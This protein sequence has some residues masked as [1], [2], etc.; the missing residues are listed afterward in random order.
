[1]EL[2]ADGSSVATNGAVTSGQSYTGYWR[3][4]NNSVGGA[5]PTNFISTYSG[6][7]DDVR[8][9][10]ARLTSTDVSN[11]YTSVGAYA[12]SGACTYYWALDATSGTS[13]ADSVGS[14]TGTLQN[15]SFP[16]HPKNGNVGTLTGFAFNS[17]DGW[18]P[19]VFGEG[20]KFNTGDYVAGENPFLASTLDNYSV[21][22][23]FNTT[24][25]GGKMAGMC[26]DTACTGRDRFLDIDSTNGKVRFV[27]YPNSCGD[28][29]STN[30]YTDGAWHFAVGTLSS[31]GMKLYVDGLL[32]ASD[33]GV[34]SGFDYG[35]SNNRAILF[36]GG[37]SLGCTNGSANYVGSL[38][39]VR[40]YNRALSATQIYDQW[41]AGR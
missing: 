16:A 18:V 15:F 11:I 33:S 17:T 10:N 19:G 31:G 4:G 41:Q 12:C 30:S 26:S 6:L 7:L 9:Y 5:G 14:N 8:Y 37:S 21:S 20:L 1:M 38:D 35:S 3:I 28:I 40:I 32:V 34:T 2:Y 22:L 29:A 23:W 39:D 36:M 24:T 13:A 25:N 27:V